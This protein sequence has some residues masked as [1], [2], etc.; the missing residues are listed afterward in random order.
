[1]PLQRQIILFLALATALFLYLGF[2]KSLEGELPSA[3]GPAASSTPT[4]TENASP[5]VTINGSRIFVEV[6]TTSAA[7]RKGLS[8]RARLE[9]DE[10]MLFLFPAPDIYRFWM[11]DMRFPLDI[12]WIYDG[13]VADISRDVSNDFDPANP[14][15]YSPRTK[16]DTVLEVNAGY[17]KRHGIEIGDPVVLRNIF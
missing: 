5:S 3:P 6:A 2:A 17:A 12:I 13:M 1:M 11:P 16:V 4:A 14:R 7:I 10:G 15:F 8:G 9:E